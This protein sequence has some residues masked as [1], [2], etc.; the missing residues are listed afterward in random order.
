M[1]KSILRA[2]RKYLQNQQEEE[3]SEDNKRYI[4]YY[5][6]KQYIQTIRGIMRIVLIMSIVLYHNPNIFVESLISDIL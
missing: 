1:I 4:E 3:N 5:K 2:K 6:K